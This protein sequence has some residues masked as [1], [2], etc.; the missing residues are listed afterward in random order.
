MADREEGT[1]GESNG[2]APANGSTQTEVDEQRS[3]ATPG[4]EARLG[5]AGRFALILGAVALIAAVVFAIYM[6][7][8]RADSPEEMTD[9]LFDALDDGDML[10]AAALI[11]PAERSF[12]VEPLLEA[13]DEAER[14]GVLIDVDPQAVRGVDFE[15]SDLTYEV[16]TLA[17]DLVWVAIAGEGGSQVEPAE[18]PLGPLLTRYLPDDWADEIVTD[19]QRQPFE[20]GFGLALVNE[21]GRWYVGLTY[22]I[23]EAARREANQDFPTQQPLGVPQGAD[24]PEGA[25]EAATLAIAQ[26]DVR[27]LIDMLSPAETAAFRRYSQ[28]FID[29]WDDAVEEARSGFAEVGLSYSIDEVVAGSQQRGDDT[30]AWIESIPRFHVAAD[31]P[32]VGL[33]AIERDGDCLTIEADDAFLEALVPLVGEQVDLSQFD[34]QQCVETDPDVNVAENPVDLLGD[35]EEILFDAPIFGPLLERWIPSS[36]DVEEGDAFQVEFEVVGEGGR[37]YVSPAGTMWRWIF[38]FTGTLD[39]A[40]LTD[41]GDQIQRLS[42]NP[43]AFEGE[44]EAWLQQLEEAGF[45]GPTGQQVFYGADVLAPYAGVSDV[46]LVWGEDLDFVVGEIT[47]RYGGE[48]IVRVIDGPELYEI[49]EAS[50]GAGATAGFVPETFPAG[51]QIAPVDVDTLVEIFNWPEIVDMFWARDLGL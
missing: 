30:V 44:M 13:V 4:Y 22:T 45:Y 34:G 33:F 38:A 15:F 25:L 28:L 20:D 7:F 3:P 9:Q 35:D 11:L 17:D 37:W 51:I 19:L 6:L 41:V 16:E 5:R 32:D 46:L 43:E 29:D 12:I 27:K 18:L 31:V 26:L 49:F 14:L 24:T 21:Q 40:L 42:E 8:L 50:L 39:Q 36:E 1:A 10:G 23:A 2:I 47:A 48:V